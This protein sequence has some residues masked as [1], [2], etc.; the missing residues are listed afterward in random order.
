MLSNQI[1][2]P[3]PDADVTDLLPFNFAKRLTEAGNLA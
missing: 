3:E 1:H 2:T